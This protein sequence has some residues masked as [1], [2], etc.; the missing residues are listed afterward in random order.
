MTKKEDVQQA[1]GYN[2]KCSL[3]FSFRKPEQIQY[4]GDEKEK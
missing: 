4:E 2:E 1:Y 3:F